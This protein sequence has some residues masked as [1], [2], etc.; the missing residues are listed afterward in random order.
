MNAREV[1][2]R[3][4]EK[5]V[6]QVDLAKKWKLPTGTI[7]Q[8]VNRKMKSERLDRRLARVLGITLEELRGDKNNKAA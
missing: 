6:R 3:L 2:Q 5:N 4:A 8:L 7:A 1:K